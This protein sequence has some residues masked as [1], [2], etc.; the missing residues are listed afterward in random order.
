MS[1]SRKQNSAKPIIIDCDP[2]IDDALALLLALASPEVKVSGITGSYGNVALS[3]TLKNI[4]RIL[5]L[6][7]IR[8][9][10]DLGRGC[11]SP[12]RGKRP[13]LRDVHGNDGMADTGLEREG[14]NAEIKDGISLIID[15]IISGEVKNVVTLGPLTNLASVIAR[16]PKVKESL[17]ELIIMGGVLYPSGIFNS[18]AEF[19]M[20]CDPYAARRVINSG[21]PIKL[22]GLN[23]TQKV[24]LREEH[25]KVFK[26][27]NNRLSE[28]ILR[29]SNF[30]IKYNKR[31]KGRTG[32]C[33]NDPLAVGM[34]IDQRLGSF[35]ELCVDVDVKRQPGRLFRK[36]GSPNVSFCNG[37][38]ADDFIR[39]FLSRL[40]NFCRDQH[41]YVG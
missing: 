36:E 1:A 16:E 7:N 20:G 37:V 41:K 24:V 34:A 13:E 17:D 12:I 11:D 3:D 23:A 35:E 8:P 40:A 22:I 38:K 15:K 4:R 14:L 31:V 6:S 26:D 32:A 18:Q 5:C 2:G 25:L 39:L 33:L 19:N 21:I 28:F 30:I 29:T 10:P 27:I 9:V